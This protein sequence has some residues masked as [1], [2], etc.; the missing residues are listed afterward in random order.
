LTPIA[1]DRLGEIDPEETDFLVVDEVHHL[2]ADSSQGRDLYQQLRVLAHGAPRLLLLSATPV[3]ADPNSTLRL[4]HLLDPEQFPL[5]DLGAFE[6]LLSNRQEYGRVL[7]SLNPTT[8]PLLLRR[9]IAKLAQLAPDDIDAG[10]LG[11]QLSAAIDD[12]DDARV[13][14][15]VRLLRDHITETYRLNRRLLRTRRRDTEGWELASRESDLVIEVD[16]DDRVE[17]AADALEEWRYRALLSLQ[18]S[19]S[20]DPAQIE[21]S[22]DALSIRFVDLLEAL[23]RG[24]DSFADALLAPYDGPSFPEETDLKRRVEALVAEAPGDLRDELGAAIIDLTLKGTQPRLPGASPKLVAFSSDSLSVR[25][26]AAS[27]SKLRGVGVCHLVTSDL[28]EEAVERAVRAF[29]E[30]RV[31]SVLLADRAGEEGLNL[32]FADAVVHLDLPMDPMRIEQRIGR[33]DRI[34][35]DAGRIRHRVLVPS[36][37]DQSPWLQWLEVCRAGL[38]V[39][40]ESIADMQF[41]LGEIL[42]AARTAAFRDGAD[43]L[44]EFVPQSRELMAAERSRLDEQ[45]AL[46]RLEMGEADGHILFQQLQ[47]AERSDTALASSMTSWWQDVLGLER[48]VPEDASPGIFRLSWTDRTLAPR[49]PWHDRVAAVLD[50][51]LTFDRAIALRNL[52]ARLVRSGNALV[53]VLPTFLR[54]DDRGSAFATWRME[55]SWPPGADPWIGFKLVFVVELDAEAIAPRLWPDPDPVATAALQRRADVLFPPWVETHF[56]DANLAAV[57]DPSLLAV[58]SRPYQKEAG[59]KS[60]RDFNLAGRFAAV[61]DFVDPFDLRRWCESLGRAATELIKG[62]PSFERHLAEAHERADRD[63]AVQAERLSRRRS[64]QRRDDGQMTDPL[65]DLE[66]ETANEILRELDSPSVRLDSVGL[67]VISHEPLRNTVSV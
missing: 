61:S 32:Q 31:P 7:L 36:D 28:N 14:G 66:I 39:F 5:D 37:E 15:A 29:R 26:V 64:A 25:Q 41:A 67:L 19:A 9:A 59:R 49:E 22:E 23:G 65:L 42:R 40:D 52:G 50:Q 10:T 18:M 2:V 62:Q 58:L 21:A 6:R 3:L 56:V 45:Y 4:L 12:G 51:P 53:E 8:A 1:L 30:A 33:L 16:E 24:V 44:R 20:P 54:H 55:P 60:S 17:A 13:A 46:D 38:R 27:V 43:G 35:R 34:G 11:Q 57:S 47:E 48:S 63:L